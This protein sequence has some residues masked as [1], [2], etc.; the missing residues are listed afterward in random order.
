M[1]FEQIRK[2]YLVFGEQPLQ[3]RQMLVMH[4]QLAAAGKDVDRRVVEDQLHRFSKFQVLHVAYELCPGAGVEDLE[5]VSDI[6]RVMWNPGF[7]SGSCLAQLRC[8]TCT[9]SPTSSDG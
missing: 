1:L 9:R 5:Q 8:I 6:L 3:V 4:V 2:L 7:Q